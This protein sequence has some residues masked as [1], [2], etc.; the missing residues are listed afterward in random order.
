MDVLSHGELLHGAPANKAYVLSKSH[1][2]YACLGSEDDSSKP[3]LLVK[4]KKRSEKPGYKMFDAD[5]SDSEPVLYDDSN[6][7][8]YRVDHVQVYSAS[9][10]IVKMA[11]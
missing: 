11:V 4:K 2:S 10:Q 8:V 3:G 1:S 9:L 7:L 6:R 5:D